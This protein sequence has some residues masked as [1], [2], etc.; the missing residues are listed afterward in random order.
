V[1]AALLACFESARW[2]AAERGSRFNAASL[3]RDREADTAFFLRLWPRLLSR[4]A[5]LLF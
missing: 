2:E 5:E 3:L 4:A 1:R